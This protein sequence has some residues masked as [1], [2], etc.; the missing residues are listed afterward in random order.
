MQSVDVLG[1]HADKLPRLFQFG[2]FIVRGVRQDAF[3]KQF[4]AVI[5]VK[6]RGMPYETFVA[7]HIFGRVLVLFA[8]QSVGASEILKSRFR[9]NAGASEKGYPFG[10]VDN[11]LKLF[12]FRHAFSYQLPFGSALKAETISYSSGV[13]YFSSSATRESV[14]KSLSE[15]FFRFAAASLSI[16]F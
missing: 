15:T 11:F 13:M 5:F 3:A 7:Q 6:I 12:D 4:F 16:P 1:N 10:G 14:S 2:E 8:V 9:R